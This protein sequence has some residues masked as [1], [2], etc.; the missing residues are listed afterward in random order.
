M[1]ALLVFNP[2]SG[3]FKPERRLKTIEE[4]ARANEVQLELLETQADT[5]ISELLNK[6]NADEIDRLWVSG[7]DG[8]VNATAQLAADWEKPL[9]VIPGGTGNSLSMSFNIPLVVSWAVKLACRGRVKRIDLV[10]L[11]H[12]P[13]MLIGGAGWDA[14]VLS[15]VG[16]EDKKRLG[17]M[18]YMK[19]VFRH[20]RLEKENWFNIKID[21]EVEITKRGQGIYIVNNPKQLKVVRVLHDS[22]PDDGLVE[23]L[24]VSS[25]GLVA[26]TLFGFRLLFGKTEDDPDVSIYKC[27]NARIN[28]DSPRPYQIDGTGVGITDTLNVSVREKAVRLIVPV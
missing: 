5:P 4:V 2:V 7:G 3:P 1:K 9:A 27:K 14:Q 21:N 12:H 22:Y 16:M 17:I 24:L 18:A 6:R 19:G 8:T 13:L 26:N 25:Q 28:I 15:E 11:N 23:V 10:E 20:M